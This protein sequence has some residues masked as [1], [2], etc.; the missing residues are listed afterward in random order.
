M[1]SGLISALPSA[2]V[3]VMPLARR[4]LATTSEVPWRAVGRGRV[5]SD[6]GFERPMPPQKLVPAPAVAV[7]VAPTAAAF[8]KVAPGRPQ[9]Q[10]DLDQ[11]AEPNYSQR[12]GRDELFKKRFAAAAGSGV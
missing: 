10:Y 2:A 3:F 5:G 8:G 4:V 7:G 9:P 6:P 1:L 11:G 12:A